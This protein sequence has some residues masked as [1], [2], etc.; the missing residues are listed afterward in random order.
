MGL[1]YEGA[2]PMVAPMMSDYAQ[3]FKALS[4]D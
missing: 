2:V 4:E 1:V 3:R